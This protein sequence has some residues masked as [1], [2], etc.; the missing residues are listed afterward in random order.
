MQ[1]CCACIA[2]VVGHACEAVSFLRSVVATIASAIVFVRFGFRHV[3]LYSTI[4]ALEAVPSTVAFVSSHSINDTTVSTTPLPSKI[5]VDVLN[6]TVF[7]NDQHAITIPLWLAGLVISLYFLLGIIVLMFHIIED[8]HI[9]R[10][11]LCRCCDDVAN[12]QQNV[13]V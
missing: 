13:V 4:I 7:Y 12:Q 2:Q 11:F 9:R 3:A 6:T 5:Y 10:R 8:I 1:S